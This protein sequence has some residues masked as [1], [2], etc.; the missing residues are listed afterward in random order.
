[1]KFA[2]SRASRGGSPFFRQPCD[3]AIREIG[4]PI[5]E[6]AHLGDTSDVWTITI[7]SLESLLAFRQQYERI[8]IKESNVTQDGKRLLE[9]T[10]YDD[11]ME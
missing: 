6:Y 9:I 1:M 7:D 11:W 5:N 8:I 4:V 2:I 3:E 10:I